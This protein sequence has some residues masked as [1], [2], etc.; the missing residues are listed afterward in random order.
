VFKHNELLM[1]EGAL[2]A[3]LPV[4]FGLLLLSWAL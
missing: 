2:A 3:I 4:A 1:I